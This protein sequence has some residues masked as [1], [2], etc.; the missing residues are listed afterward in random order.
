MNIKMRNYNSPA[1][2]II[3]LETEYSI[4]NDSFFGGG[5]DG[6]MEPGELSF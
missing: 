2:E 6:E 5:D 1:C 4:M 3:E